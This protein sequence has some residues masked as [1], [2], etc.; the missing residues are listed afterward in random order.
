MKYFIRELL[1]IFH[2][3]CTNGT[4]VGLGRDYC[5]PEHQRCDGRDH[6]SDGS[7]EHGCNS[8]C[9]PDN[10]KCVNGVDVMFG[11]PCIPRTYLCDRDNDCTGLCV[12]YFGRL[13]NF[14][15]E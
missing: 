15:P 13:Q 6:C 8:V 5:I 10:F 1:R 2:S 7:D 9:S 12:S 11:D 3:R 4:I 14:Q